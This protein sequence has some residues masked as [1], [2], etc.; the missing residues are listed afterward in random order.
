MKNLLLSA[1]AAAAIFGSANAFALGVGDDAPCVVLNQIATDGSESEFCI[2]E[3]KAPGQ[4]VLL[5]FFSATCSDC[6]RNLPIISG[7]ADEIRGRA[8]VRAVGIDRNE[9][10]LRNFVGQYRDLLSY[11][12]A[13]DTSRDAKQAYGVVSTPT[14]FVLNSENKILYKHTGVLS[15]TDL[16]EIRAL[17]AE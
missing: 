1:F 7:F 11:D 9:S 13:L 16:N 10:L 8:T 3:P 5:E 4:L 14:L 15:E 12:V 17:I 6:I 2:R